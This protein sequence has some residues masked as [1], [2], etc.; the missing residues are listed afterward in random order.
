MGHS[1]CVSVAFGP[2]LGS[3]GCSPK[4]PIYGIYGRTATRADPHLRP[5]H[6][7]LYKKV[8]KGA[9]R[10]VNMPAVPLPHTGSLSGD[11]KGR[12][13]AASPSPWLPPQA[14]GGYPFP[15]GRHPTDPAR[16]VPG[17][18]VAPG[19]VSGGRQALRVGPM[20]GGCSGPY[21]HAGQDCCGPAPRVP[22]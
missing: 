6:A 15:G 8:A 12:R 1:I 7:R 18:W 4:G 10:T 13:W 16:P 11:A 5:K 21:P 9:S 14:P 22:G 2:Q 17:G 3:T 20:V 19:D